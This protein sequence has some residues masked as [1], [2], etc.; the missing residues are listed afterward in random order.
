[1]VFKTNKIPDQ[2]RVVFFYPIVK[3]CDWDTQAFGEIFKWEIAH[4]V[5]LSKSFSDIPA[6]W[7]NLY[8]WPQGS[9]PPPPSC[10]GHRACNTVDW[11]KD[12]DDGDND[13]GY[14]DDGDGDGDNDDVGDDNDDD[15]VGDDDDDDDDDGNLFKYHMSS[16]IGSFTSDQGWKENNC[17]GKLLKIFKNL[18]WKSKLKILK[19]LNWKSWIS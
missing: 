1:M 15:D 5:W 13:D 16:H 14:D 7:P 17:E 9:R 6:N 3:D 18:N 11:D 8:L 19:S 10:S 2:V 4:L 12:D